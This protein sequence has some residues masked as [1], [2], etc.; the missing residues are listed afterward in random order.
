VKRIDLVR[1]LEATRG[2]ASSVPGF[3]R[4]NLGPAESPSQRLLWGKRKKYREHDGCRDAEDDE[5]CSD[6]E[7]DEGGLP[8]PPE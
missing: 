1:A 2:L 5:P 6:Q 7:L 3:L 4:L 8:A